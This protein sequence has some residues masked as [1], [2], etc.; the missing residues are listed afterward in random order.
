MI[1]LRVLEFSS[2]LA[3]G[4]CSR[5]FVAAGADV[6][7]VEPP[8]GADLRRIGPWMQV[9]GDA[10]PRS[11]AWEYAAAGKRSV[12]L[13][14]EDAEVDRL[15]AWAELVV[16]DFEGDADAAMVFH[17]RV[18]RAN[19]AAVHVV[20]S[21]YGLT[22][23]Y[24]NWRH[25]PLTEWAAGGHLYLTGEPGR[26]PLQGGGPWASYLTG[27]TAAIGAA[28]ALFDSL[29]SGVG[30]L[31]DVGAMEAM[32]GL[33]QWTITIF[34]HLGYVKRR[35]GNLLGESSHPIGLYTCSDGW[36]SIVAVALHQWESLC[37]AMELW[38]LLADTRLEV[39]AERF[40]R[41][42]EIDAQINE[43]L[44]TR[45]VD[46]AVEFL[47][48]RN[49]P[50]S[51][52]L[53]MSDVLAEPQLE[54]RSFWARPKELG[55]GA[56]M[57]GQ[58]FVIDGL[59]VEI[60]P[61]PGI[62]EHREEV[63]A[64]LGE[65]RGPRPHLDLADVRALEFGVAWAGPLAGRFLGDLGVDVIKVEHPSS[66]GLPVDAEKAKGWKWGELPHPQVRFPVYPDNVP[67]E[68]WWNRAGMFNKMNRSKRSVA[69][70]AKAG[71]GP[72]IL[73][74]LIGAADLVLHNYSPRGAKSLGI[75]SAAV[76]AINPRGMTVSLTGYGAGG[77]LAAN[78]SYG[79]VLQ[80]HGGFDEATGYEGGG[81][82]R[83]GVAF[84]DA[85][86]R[87]ARGLHRSRGPLEPGGRRLGRLRRRVPARD[88]S[89]HRRRHAARHVGHRCR[90]R[91][92]RQP[93]GRLLPP[94]RVPGRRR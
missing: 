17:E 65:Q 10:E 13:S 63:F 52:L 74:E 32:A 44:S 25:S 36:I 77:P 58:P 82:A 19:P 85:V 75:D 50:A 46:E 29:R 57:P 80:A 18:K 3:A 88:P 4:Y 30:Q 9:D 68:R 34:T 7:C 71:E 15:L 40:D 35:W 20:V 33:H 8:G 16:S 59:R 92:P 56:Q 2:S 83:L 1:G 12:A 23:P 70:D 42:A 48:G 26:E 73:H 28:A 54:V 43:W 11:A 84:P 27:A 93:V 94:E 37:V 5:L 14:L 89:G 79:P 53:T 6:V 51:R 31:V 22:G 47:Q 72:R 91:A 60:P 45:T 55:E 64:G 21:G 69:L 39:I 61:A 81:P 76:Q 24:R 87:G 66:R 41:A 86:G 90:P 38:D 67:G 62:D 49:V 78:V